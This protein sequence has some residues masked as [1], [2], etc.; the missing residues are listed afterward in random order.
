MWRPDTYIYTHICI[1][2]LPRTFVTKP[3]LVQTVAWRSNASA[4]GRGDSQQ[5]QL[6]P[7]LDSPGS[8]A[9]MDPDQTPKAKRMQ[10]RQTVAHAT[11]ASGRLRRPRP[12][13]T[14]QG[15]SQETLSSDSSAEDQQGATESMVCVCQ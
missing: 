9:N 15:E 11:R 10:N 8:G 13:N 4:I 5:M 12:L 3:L 6:V 14:V 2:A 7:G 1:Q